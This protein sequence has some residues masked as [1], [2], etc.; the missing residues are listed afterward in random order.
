MDVITKNIY[1]LLVQQNLYLSRIQMVYQHVNWP[2]IWK[3]V[4]SCS[5]NIERTILYRYIYSVAPVGEYFVRYGITNKIPK[6]LMCNSGV[7]T[8]K[9]F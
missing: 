3:S 8:E 1:T 6:Y 7:F 5:S 9:L 2:V 4:W